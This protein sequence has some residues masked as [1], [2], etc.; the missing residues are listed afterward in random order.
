MCV[1][2]YLCF[3]YDKYH[4]QLACLVGWNLELTIGYSAPLEDFHIEQHP[5]FLVVGWL[6]RVQLP[7]V[8]TTAQSSQS[9]H[10]VKNLFLLL[11]LKQLSISCCLCLYFIYHSFNHSFNPLRSYNGLVCL[12]LIVPAGEE[13]D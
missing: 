6:V 8:Q 13:Q 4:H 10:F 11:F 7:L 2:F 5:C 3:Y 1:F 12:G 9:N